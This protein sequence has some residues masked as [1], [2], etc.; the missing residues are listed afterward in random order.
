MSKFEGTVEGIVYRNADNGWTVASLRLDGSKSPIAAVGVMPFLSEGE[1]GT[2]D[3]EIVEHKD[4]GRQIKVVG[5]EA[6][7]PQTKS[8]V[9]RFLASG[10]I[11]GV[12]KAMAKQIVA[13]F[14]ARTL[15]VLESEPERLTEVPGIGRKK[16]AMIA[17]SFAEH[18]G[19]RGTLMFLQE[20]GL[21]P[22][23]S[24]K[25]YR[26]YGDTTERVLRS[27]P[28]RLA[29]EIAGVGFRTA[30]DIAMRLGFGR[31]SEF[32]LR[33]GIKYALTE[34]ANGAGHMYL[35]AG[36]LVDQACR[37]LDAEA[38][39]VERE[40]RALLI[41]DQLIAEK[42][43]DDDAVYL[44]RYHRAERDTARLLV[45]QLRSIKPPRF[46]DGELERLVADYEAGEGVALCAQQRE[47][48]LA[49]AK[50][51]I[52]IIT[53]GPGTGKTTSIN[54][55]IRVM[56]RLG[57]VELCA[58][59]GRAARRMSEA[60][61]CPAQTIHRLL[62]YSGEGQGFMKNADD[63]LD[64]DVVIVDEMSMV[65]IFLMKSLLSALRP[66]TRL[67]LVGDADQ[68]PSVGAGNVLRDL[69]AADALRV[70]RLTE[71]FRQAGQSQIVLNAHLVNRGEYP[72]IRVRDTDFFLERKDTPVQAAASTV[73]L[74][75]TR[76]P[77]Y[78]GFDA[79][80]DIQVMAPMKRGEVGVFHLNELLQAALNPPGRDV[81]ELQHGQTVFRRGDKVMQVRNNYD[82][83]WERGGEEGDGVFNGDIGYVIAVDRKERA[84]VVEF[85]DGRVA[86]Y[87][88][89]LL[90]DL[91]LAYCMSV[92]K[93]QGSE[94]DA[95][96]LPL[97]SGPPMLM[98]RNLLYT[99]ITRAKRLVVLVGREGCVRQMVDNNHITR[100]YSALDRRLAD[101]AGRRA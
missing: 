98:T 26:A 71:I 66:G 34:A 13:Y 38:A 4:Y 64:A 18:N 100:R 57:A 29:D 31:E 14:G 32:R 3:G 96:V 62:E 25:V 85:D 51:G 49:A 94:F 65:D 56:R 72:V 63:P 22:A 54:L 95:V 40:L 50:E 41:E 99:A 23:L 82:L 58:P 44:P 36:V 69:I 5:Y 97:V 37:M 52:C 48:V 24:L 39:L 79:L 81:P 89:G 11:K 27:N 33:S 12:R 42:V 88:E 61:G 53:G 35:P 93:S 86:E 1:H 87:D 43:G 101:A 7:R 60:T 16:A 68:L 45:K 76:L 91:E 8:G 67:I 59:T 19:M 21:T 90:D 92:H 15:D 47:A 84:L 9:E 17:Q 28:Y 78:M 20:Y 6:T 55:I 83:A 74:V 80:R 75:R 70:V 2:F 30:D 73:A 77:N 46:S 10:L